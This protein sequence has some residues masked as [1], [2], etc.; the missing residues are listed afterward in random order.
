[1][2]AE[3]IASALGKSTRSGKGFK[4][5][6]PAHDDKNP[7]LVVRDTEHGGIFVKCYAGCSWRDVKNALKSRGLWPESGGTGTSHNW[8]KSGSRILAPVPDDAPPISFDHHP[9]GQPD[10]LYAY[11]DLRGNLIGYVARWDRI[12]GKEMRPFVFAE[13]HGER[14]WVSKGLPEPRPLYLGEQLATRVDVRVLLVEGEKAAEAAATILPNIVTC[15]WAGGAEAVRKSDWGGLAGRDVI[16]WPDNDPP[17]QEAMQ[18]VANILKNVAKSVGKVILP[19]HLPPKWDLGDTVPAAVDVHAL[20]SSAVPVTAGLRR[21]ILSAEELDELPIEPREFVVEPIFV[22]GGLFMMYAERGLGKTWFALQASID[23]AQGDDFFG[24]EVPSPRFV[25]YVDGE[26]SLAEL[27]SR[28]RS[29]GGEKA[30]RLLLLPSE[31]LFQEDRPLNISNVDDQARIVAAL[32]ELEKEGAGPDLVVFDNLSSLSGGVDENDNSALDGLLR[33]L[34]KIK[35]KKIAVLLVHHAGKSGDQRGAS[36][37]EDLLD[38]SIALVRRKKGDDDLV[39]HRGAE[40][41]VRFMKTRGK[42]PA[43]NDFLLQLTEIPEGGVEWVVNDAPN[44][45]QRDNVLRFI[46]RES[47]SNQRKIADGLGLSTGR[48]SQLCS[49]LRDA[50]HLKQVGLSITAIGR[51]RLLRL[52]PNL[53]GEIT[54]QDDLPI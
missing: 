40:F 42:A 47:P 46:A 54:S 28:I 38:T 11:R 17:G 20:L 6:C 25:L 53:A 18:E 10:H 8:Q 7:S 32:D 19:D 3:S 4:C 26:M 24:F 21:H 1:M 2:N 41:V 34:V 23:I 51:Q 15:T 31:R 48:I 45:S 33:W 12:G 29:L 44:V 36:R 37:R 5:C 13:E 52:W 50:G 30:T 35:H 22:K 27:Q 43:R 49:Q 39:R 9:F 14:K 16:L